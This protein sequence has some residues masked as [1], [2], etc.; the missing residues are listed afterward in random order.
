MNNSAARQ[1]IHPAM[2]AQLHLPP[3]TSLMGPTARADKR[4]VHARSRSPI[5]KYLVRRLS[6][7]HPSFVLVLHVAIALPR[8]VFAGSV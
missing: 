3:F 5:L 6:C 8:V 2:R 7:F 4:V 1:L